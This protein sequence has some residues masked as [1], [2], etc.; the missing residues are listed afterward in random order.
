MIYKGDI[1]KIRANQRHFLLVL[2]FLEQKQ[3]DMSYGIV[4]LYVHEVNS[5]L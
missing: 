1:V 2:F 4:Q 3:C 5:G